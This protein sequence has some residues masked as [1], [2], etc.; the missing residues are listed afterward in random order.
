MKLINRR[1]FLQAAAGVSALNYL[2]PIGN[3]AEL[4]ACSPQGYG[5]GGEITFR[6]L[7]HG[8]FAVVFDHSGITLMPPIVEKDTPHKYL[9]T[10]DLNG[11]FTTLNADQVYE[12]SV[13][14]EK[15]IKRPSVYENAMIQYSDGIQPNPNAKPHC[16]I[17]VPLPQAVVPLRSVTPKHPDQQPLFTNFSG[18]L[19]SPVQLPLVTMLKY[20]LGSNGAGDDIG[21]NYHL[22]AEPDQCPSDIHSPEAFNQ[23]KSL[24]T[25]LDDLQ[26]NTTLKCVEFDQPLDPAGTGITKDDE[27][28]LVELLS[29]V[30]CCTQSGSKMQGASGAPERSVISRPR[31]GSRPQLAVH[32]TACMSLIVLP[33]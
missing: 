33:Q 25:G 10:G 27:V 26:L 11:P 31:G 4:S 8:M 12:I 32:P 1:T 29:D 6:L 19:A 23:L 7:L 28:A 18:L 30:D 9:A 21:I 14:G 22:F 2:N 5:T 24:F 3:A 20:H 15:I 16:Y 13:P 17:R